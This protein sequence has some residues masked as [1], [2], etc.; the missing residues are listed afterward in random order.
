MAAVNPWAARIALVVPFRPE[1][2][3]RAS[4]RCSSPVIGP[5]PSELPLDRG[6]GPSVWVSITLAVLL[7]RVVLAPVIDGAISTP[8]TPGLPRVSH[9]QS[10]RRDFDPS[11]A[12]RR[13]RCLLVKA[14]CL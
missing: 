1:S 5:A 13:P 10:D 11:S 3:S 6:I 2:A 12:R 7:D 4:A 9:Q 8:Q 14:G